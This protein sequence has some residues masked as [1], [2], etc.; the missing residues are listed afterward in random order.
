[1]IDTNKEFIAIAEA[2]KL[3]IPVIAILTVIVTLMAL[4]ISTGN[5]DATR[6]IELYCSLFSGP[7]LTAERVQFHQE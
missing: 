2:Q 7:L 4:L 5:D 3:G 6:A 1:M